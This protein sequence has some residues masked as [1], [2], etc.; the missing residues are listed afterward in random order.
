L[1][2]AAIVN[3]ALSGRTALPPLTVAPGKPRFWKIYNE[4]SWI[5]G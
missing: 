1:A 2:I 5:D 3:G 4:N